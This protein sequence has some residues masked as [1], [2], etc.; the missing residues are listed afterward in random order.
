MLLAVGWITLGD[1]IIHG[2]AGDTDASFHLQLAKGWLFVGL[3]GGFIYWLA[4]RAEHRWLAAQ[5]TQTAQAEHLEVAREE[6]R[7]RLA[8]DIHDDVGAGLSGLRMSLM[9]LERELEG[10][11]GHELVHSI[12]KDLTGI[13][14]SVRR[15]SAGLR[16]GVL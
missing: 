15:L 10:A 14:Q 7:R 13:I 9:L 2:I 3:S 12:E 4:R 16:P 1:L 8:M 6:E 11:R 5:A